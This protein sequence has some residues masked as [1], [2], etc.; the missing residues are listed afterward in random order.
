MERV[1]RAM[2]SMATRRGRSRFITK[3]PMRLP[4]PAIALGRL[5]SDAMASAATAAGSMT[6]GAMR[7]IFRGAEAT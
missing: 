5:P 4:R 1:V 7:E 6:A 2:I 3:L